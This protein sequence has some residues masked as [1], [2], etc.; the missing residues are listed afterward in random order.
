MRDL[1]DL[2]RLIV[3]Q[4]LLIL[5]ATENCVARVNPLRN[6]VLA[7]FVRVFLGIHLLAVHNLD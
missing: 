5:G 1:Y 3:S 2:S 4:C 6:P 7:L